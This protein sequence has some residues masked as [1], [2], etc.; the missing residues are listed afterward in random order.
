[1]EPFLPLTHSLQQYIFCFFSITSG[2]RTI[3]ES[4]PLTKFSVRPMRLKTESTYY[5][6]GTEQPVY[7][8]ACVS[9]DSDERLFRSSTRIL[10]NF[11]VEKVIKGIYI[12]SL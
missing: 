9:G 6:R 3:C 10:S 12:I 8:C 1:M 4:V 7:M 5:P 11:A 2:T